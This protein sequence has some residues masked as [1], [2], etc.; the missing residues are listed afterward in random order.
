MSAIDRAMIKT[1]Y[2]VLRRDLARQNNKHE[3]RLSIVPTT[4]NRQPIIK[5]DK[6]TFEL[7]ST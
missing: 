2:G 6:I 4:V 1:A 7:A 3:Q 5:K